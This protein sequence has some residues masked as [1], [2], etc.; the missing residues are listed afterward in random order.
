VTN[1][2]TAEAYVQIQGRAEVSRDEA[3]RKAYWKDELKTYFSGP[4]DPNYSVVIVRPY[5]IELQ[6]MASMEP[7]VWEA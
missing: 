6:T 5:R 2:Q 3:E 7:E 1:P 4:D